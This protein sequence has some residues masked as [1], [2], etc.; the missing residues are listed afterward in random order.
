MPTTAVLRSSAVRSAPLHHAVR[1]LDDL[2]IDEAGDDHPVIR[3]QVLELD[4]VSIDATALG[5]RTIF[6]GHGEDPRRH[7]ESGIHVVEVHPEA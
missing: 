6:L 5:V 4:A 1:P 7:F 2:L 3:F